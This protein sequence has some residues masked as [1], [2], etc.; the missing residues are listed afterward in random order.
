MQYI[1]TAWPTLLS[2]LA[3]EPINCI[4]HSLYT[5]LYIQAFSGKLYTHSVYMYITLVLVWF[6][7]GSEAYIHGGMGEKQNVACIHWQIPTPSTCLMPR[8]CWFIRFQHVSERILYRAA[9]TRYSLHSLHFSWYK[10]W[11]HYTLQATLSCLYILSALW[12]ANQL[13]WVAWDA[14][15]C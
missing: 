8:K 14:W 2:Q 12:L 6:W 7:P 11:P 13:V 9:A 4:W 5:A 15:H 3:S 1:Y 10:F